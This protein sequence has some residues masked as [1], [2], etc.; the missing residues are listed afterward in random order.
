MKKVDIFAI[1]GKTSRDNS[2]IM[3]MQKDNIEMSIDEFERVYNE[4]CQYIADAEDVEPGEGIGCKTYGGKREGSGRKPTGR[5]KQ[6]I[7]VTNEEF[8]KIKAFIEEL[9]NA[10]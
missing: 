9:R 2:V 6:Q 1:Q 8:V 3:K 7:Y 10:E 5:K 4:G